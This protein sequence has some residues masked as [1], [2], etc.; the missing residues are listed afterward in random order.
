[1]DRGL[2]AHIPAGYAVLG[3]LMNSMHFQHLAWTIASSGHWLTLLFAGAVWV[4]AAM[5]EHARSLAEEN[6]SFV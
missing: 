5:M 4:M 3:V 1:M 6:A 2:R